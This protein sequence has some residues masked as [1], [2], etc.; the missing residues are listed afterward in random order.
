MRLCKTSF[1]RG[2]CEEWGKRVGRF[3]VLIVENGLP[4][5]ITEIMRNLSK[6]C[7][8]VP[9]AISKEVRE[10]LKLNDRPVMDEKKFAQYASVKASIKNLEEEADG[11]KSAIEAEMAKAGIEKQSTVFGEFKLQGRKVWTYP[12]S[13]KTLEEKWK[14]G[15]VEAEEKGTATYVETSSLWFLPTKI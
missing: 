8:C 14:I 9:L 11:I 13:V 10:L 15:K 2:R 4:V 1:A 6:S 5:T 12:K 3:D 7:R